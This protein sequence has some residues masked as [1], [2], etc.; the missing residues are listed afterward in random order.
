MDLLVG[1]GLL[2]VLAAVFSS[3][4]YSAARWIRKRNLNDSN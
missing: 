1:Y 4:I 2:V 3:G